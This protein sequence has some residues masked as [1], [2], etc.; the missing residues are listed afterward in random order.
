MGLTRLPEE[1]EKI[2]ISK[3]N[4]PVWQAE[5]P[6]LLL[7]EQTGFTLLELTIVLFLMTLMLGVVGTNFYKTWQREQLKMSLRQVVGTLRQA[8]SE[9]VSGN[10]KV[11]VQFDLPEQR[12]WVPNVS[13]ELRPLPTVMADTALLVWQDQNRRQGHITFYGDGSSSGGRLTFLGPGKLPFT[14]E[15]DRITGQINLSSR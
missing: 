3:N 5:A 14:L 4:P 2:K 6:L 13:K 10:R 7:T 12:Y 11:Q 9:A 8:R 1:K 15:V